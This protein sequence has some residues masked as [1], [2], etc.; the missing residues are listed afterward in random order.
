MLSKDHEKVAT[1]RVCTP[2][3][4]KEREGRATV[5]VEGKD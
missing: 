2:Q 3:A 5:E 4:K 1:V